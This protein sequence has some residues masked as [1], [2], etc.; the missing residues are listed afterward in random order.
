MFFLANAYEAQNCASLMPF[1]SRFDDW[2]QT[3]Q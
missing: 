2:Q 3:W 1:L